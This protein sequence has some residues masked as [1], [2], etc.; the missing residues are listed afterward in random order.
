MK[1]NEI[2]MSYKY[3]SKEKYLKKGGKTENSYQKIYFLK[4]STS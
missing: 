1:L 2:E 4:P 3:K